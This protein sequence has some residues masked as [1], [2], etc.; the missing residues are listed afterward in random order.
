L[1]GQ[2]MAV[3]SGTFVSSVEC[4]VFGDM[5]GPGSWISSGGYKDLGQCQPPTRVGDRDEA[6]MKVLACAI[7]MTGGPKRGPLRRQWSPWMMDLV[8]QT[9]TRERRQPMIPRGAA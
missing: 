8:L 5:Y 4:R 7:G 2:K 3:T 1:V 6:N 9:D